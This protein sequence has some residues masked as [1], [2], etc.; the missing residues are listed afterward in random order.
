MHALVLDPS[1]EGVADGVPNLLNESWLHKTQSLVVLSCA[2]CDR[3]SLSFFCG[4]A[5]R[6]D[7]NQIETA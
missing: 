6:G 7:W 1:G 5:I 2:N 4:E 3:F